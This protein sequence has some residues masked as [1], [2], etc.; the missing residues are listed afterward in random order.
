MRSWDCR[1]KTTKPGCQ[2]VGADHDLLVVPAGQR[3]LSRRRPTVVLAGTCT[4]WE[5]A[6]C[7]LITSAAG[8]PVCGLVVVV[9][10][11]ATPPSY[12]FHYLILPFPHPPLLAFPCIFSHFVHILLRQTS[13]SCSVPGKSD[14]DWGLCP[15]FLREFLDL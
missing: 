1:R 4:I 15:P 2:S 9:P 14:R 10:S 7:W 8:L 13:A 6:V 5:R 11:S 12:P 3:R